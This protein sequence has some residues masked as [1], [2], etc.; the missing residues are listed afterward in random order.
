MKSTAP[1]LSLRLRRLA[2]L[3]RH[4]AS[5]LS[6]CLI[7]LVLGCSW[8]TDGEPSHTTVA[9]TKSSAPQAV[10]AAQQPLTTAEVPE[11]AN[12]E[13]ANAEQANADA[14]VKAANSPA[15]SPPYTEVLAEF[16]RGAVLMEKYEYA[17]AGLAFL[18]VLK[19]EP[20]WSA[21]RFNL[22]LAY[23]NMVGENN[24]QKRIGTYEEM[25]AGAVSSLESLLKDD[26]DNPRYL[27]C[28]GMIKSYLGD[29]EEALGYF[30][31]VYAQDKD[32]SF[33]ALSYAKALSSLDRFEEAI[34]I[35]EPVVERDPGFIS[36][37]YVL[38]TLYRR[39][40]NIARAKELLERH[41]QL[42]KE[43]LSVGSYVVADKYGMAGKYYLVLGADGHPVPPPQPVP[44][45]RI[46]FAPEP[47]SLAG[48]AAIWNYEGGAIG[49]PGVAVADV[50][51]DQDLDL[52]I[53]GVEAEGQAALYT[54]D[55]TGHFSPGAVLADRVVSPCFG[56]IDNDGDVDLW[57][58]RSGG[59][60]VMLNNG[61]GG[62]QADSHSSAAGSEDL[63]PVARLA[64]IDSDG[65]LDLLAMRWLRG[66]IPTGE[67]AAAAPSSVWLN[68]TDGTFVD[69]AAEL[70]LQLA[71]APIAAIVLD[72]FDNDFD[73]DLVAFSVQGTPL[74]WTNFRA[75]Q[76]RLVNSAE[77]G[78]NV[79][80]A[81]SATSGDLD[82]DGDRDLLVF[83][84]SGIRLF[85]N[86]GHFQ[87]TEDR[88]F[89]ATCG[90]FG[91]T[92]GQFVDM[93]NDGDLDILVADAKRSDG[94]CGPVL[95]INNWPAIGFTDASQID[96][97][98][99]LSVL[100]TPA[101]ASC[102][103]ADFTGNGRCDVLLVAPGQQ[104]VLVENIT[105]GGNW[106]EFDLIG[107]RPQDPKARSSNSAIAARVEVRTG[108]HFQQYVV[109]GSAGP[110]SSVPLRIHAGL[111][112][113][114]K[115]DWLRL[116]WPDAILQ[117]EVEL[118]ANRLLTV[119]EISRKP[120]SCPYLFAWDGSQFAFVGD[121]GGVGGLGYYVGGGRYAQPDSTEYLP[122]P[123]LAPLDG[124]YV[125]QSLTPLEEITYFDEV[126][127]LAV[128]HPLGTEVYPNEMMAIGVSP[129]EF[130]LFCF[131]ERLRPQRA[132]DQRGQDITDQL[133]RADRRYAGATTPD[134]RFTGL[135]DP[136]SVELDFGDELAKL[137]PESR[138]VLFLYGWV[139]Y[140]YS[141]TNYA[142]NQAGLRGE[143]PTLEVWRDGKWV[144]LFRE[145]G[146]PAG[147][148]HMMTVEVTG[149]VLPG[150]QRLR[151]SSNLEL[152]WDEIFLAKLDSQATV[153]LHEVMPR[154]ADLHFRGY[155]REYSPDG[156]KPNLCD[157]HNLDR[158]VA[159]KLMS[160]DYTRFGDVRT[161]LDLTDDCYVIMGH[162]EE[163]TLRFAVDQFGP[164]PSGC[165]RSF[166]LKTDSY[167]KDMDLHTAFPDTVEPLP[168][169]GMS[170][171]PYGPGEEYPDNDKTR[172]YRDTWNTRR[173]DGR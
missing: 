146:Y 128:D 46:L 160:G 116:L 165:T 75:G 88:A 81:S 89:T 136:H 153:T 13:Q 159:W 147:V 79:D 18:K 106:I 115:V 109:G 104:P 64:D 5:C 105:P 162:G 21:A 72:D 127:L 150:D 22:A 90:R 31:R 166:I 155:P 95:L 40:K 36:A 100:N 139:E 130:E 123:P 59:D 126:K 34:P 14:N 56:D 151:I 137:P 94:S 102:V 71:D 55:G 169:H 157:Y 91:G 170:G 122:L 4:S 156:Q 149:K 52:L 110:V 142:A 24:P 144:E 107:K 1:P 30:E 143:A 32:D 58:G 28:L 42:I 57:C 101:G 80:G 2:G 20:D 158:N 45:R 168:F 10:P 41:G 8:Q 111:G 119:E 16:N 134:P 163:I 120:S 69:H 73:L 17:L 35:L 140:G 121:F 131:R 54:N 103:A 108:A 132:V 53:T 114:A 167:C 87:F 70:G 15:D 29:T 161:L 60:Q 3:L 164:T 19:Q 135:A 171:Y 25:S 86:N 97:G 82:K 65:D 51:N 84:P 6:F 83:T 68:K 117:G 125:L 93:D 9:T 78:L 96:A 124:H 38:A 23:T 26:P 27:Y 145:V 99:L 67:G 39:T 172:Q 129:P 152:Y 173:I 49:L 133:Q 98:N 66:S 92:G 113:H 141:S 62:F 112:D 7:V 148:N 74:S 11:Q 47:R 118:A 76:Y 77:T 33:A 44:A 154:E 48:Q 12:A 61:Q 85:A 138:L 50:D 63:T 43:E 37:H